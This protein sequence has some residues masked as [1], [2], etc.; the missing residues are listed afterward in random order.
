MKF[1]TVLWHSK[2]SALLILFVGW[3]A[4][5]QS[6]RIGLRLVEPEDGTMVRPGT[7]IV[8]LAEVEGSVKDVTVEFYRNNQ[9]IG[10][11]DKP[12]Y[13]WL[14]SDV[15]R[16]TSLLEAKVHNG[17]NQFSSSPVR[18]RAHE[19][20]AILAF[21]L[22]EVEQF[23]PKLWGK[24]IWEYLASLVYLIL[25]LFISG[26]LDVI[27]RVL[28]KRWA[29]AKSNA[30]A[31]LVID[32]LKG[33]L[34]IICLI[35][36][37]NAG[38]QVFLWPV[39]VERWLMMLLSLVMAA[40]LTYG[41]L[42]LSDLAISRWLR[43]TIGHDHRE[44][45][46][47]V[48][49]ILRKIAKVLIVI[50]AILVT[51]QNVF[52]KDVTTIL[53]S[54]SIGGLAIGLAAQDTLGN[55]FGAM[56]IFVDKP[57]RLGD[58]VKLGGVEGAVESIGLRSTK[59]RSPEGFLITIPNKT[60]G[61]ATIINLSRRPSVKTDLVFTVPYELS[62]DKIDRAATILQ[63]VFTAHSMTR[64]AIVGVNKFSDSGVNILVN[65]TWKA[66]DAGGYPRALQEIHLEVKRRFD[67][68]GI[69]FACPSRNIHL[70]LE[71]NGH[72]RLNSFARH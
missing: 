68:E 2:R 42:Q 4:F 63:E 60:M 59:V 54:L 53:A 72:D 50:I 36:L 62:A 34:R 57:F 5:G 31:A 49:P 37:I 13:R 1:T 16:G 35:V 10:S 3:T 43:R 67:Q 56:S 24:P 7:N 70:S 22:D 47:Q 48:L 11:V 27:A 30:I 33:P 9:F 55:L 23:R 58:S 71:S 61:T 46:E 6:P 17:T 12:P 29:A 40:S 15:P 14:W 32:L 69:P 21:G 44:I 39:G 64:E 51:C 25:A 20:E 38:L 28:L 52:Q 65:H 19:L 45:D 8:L 41:G 26:L 18:V 66:G